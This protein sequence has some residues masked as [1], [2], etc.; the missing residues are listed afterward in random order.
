MPRQNLADINARLRAIR[1][2]ITFTPSSTGRCA[3]VME[4]LLCGFKNFSIHCERACVQLRAEAFNGL[5]KGLPC[6]IEENS[7]NK[8]RG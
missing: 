7:C 5:S 1:F 2:V 3:M 4:L 8:L 6:R